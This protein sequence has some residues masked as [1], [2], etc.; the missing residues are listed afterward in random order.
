MSCGYG[1]G[2]GHRPPYGGNGCYRWDWPEELDP[3]WIGR[4]RPRG[5]QDEPPVEALE[6]QLAGLTGAIRRLEIELAELRARGA[7]GRAGVAGT[8]ES[9]DR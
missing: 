6:M 9:G 3:R 5:R 8:T 2:H 1:C 7:V 4:D